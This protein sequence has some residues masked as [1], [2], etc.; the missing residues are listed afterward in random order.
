MQRTISKGEWTPWGPFRGNDLFDAYVGQGQNPMD[1]YPAQQTGTD[2]GT[3]HQRHDNFTIEEQDG[4]EEGGHHDAG[5][6]GQDYSN[7]G[8]G[9]YYGGQSSGYYHD[10]SGQY[11]VVQEQGHYD[12]GTSPQ[13]DVVNIPSDEE[14]M[15]RHERIGSLDSRI[16]NKARATISGIKNEKGIKYHEDKHKGYEH[17]SRN[18]NSI[19]TYK[20]Y[21]R[22]YQPLIFDGHKDLLNN[23]WNGYK[24]IKSEY[25][26]G[27]YGTTIAHYCKDARFV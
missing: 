20:N 12:T 18:L 24:A 3:S 2:A 17:L 26:K 5:T 25:K 7:Q 27:G 14:I 21:I 9:Q 19:G 22:S 15:R 1:R 6:S 16:I 13:R 23:A 8:H 11:N 10:G 4:Y